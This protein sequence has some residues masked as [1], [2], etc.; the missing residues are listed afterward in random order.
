[1]RQSRFS[2]IFAV[3]LTIAIA[4][5]GCSSPAMYDPKIRR[6]RLLAEN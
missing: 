6:D 4:C 1:M 2:M 5:A 3:L